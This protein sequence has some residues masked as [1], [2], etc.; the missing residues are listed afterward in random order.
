[1]TQAD[2]S[3]PDD[4]RSMAMLIAILSASNFI[5][6]MGAFVV[7]GLLNPISADLGVSP[8]AA[9]QIM[10]TYALAYAIASPLLVAGTGRVGRRRVLAFSLGAFALA[11]L[12]S[13]MAPGEV[14][15]HASR[16]LAAAGAGVFTPVAAAV[17]AG[18]SPPERRARALAAV[19]FGLTLAQVAG[20]PAGSFIAFTYGWRAA[21][22]LVALLALPCLWLIWTRI[23]RGLAFQPVSLNDLTRTLGNWPVMLAVSFTALFLGAIYVLYT[24][25]SPLLAETMGFGRDG[26]SLALLAFGIGAVLGNILGGIATDR[27]GAFRTLFA[28]SLAQMAIMPFFSTLP[29]P[30]WLTLPMI[31]LWSTCG[32]SFM[33]AQ[34]VRLIG[35]SRDGPSV[36]LALNA[37]AIYVGAALGAALGGFV[38]AAY[39]VDALGYAAGLFASIAIVALLISKRING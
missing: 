7:I 25:L 2:H 21:F 17:A 10:T 4:Q 16:I 33:A 18:L 34:Q 23:P 15:L 30:V 6:G 24:Y 36:V 38:I 19:F 32:W 11:N 37:A 14:T 28:L 1:M 3:H 13:A 29:L 26:I 39:G 12:L 5:I 31:G 8:G 27:I 20:V 35:L 22:I 9:G